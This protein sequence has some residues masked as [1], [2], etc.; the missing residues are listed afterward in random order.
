MEGDNAED[1]WA[2]S[3]LDNED[4]KDEDDADQSSM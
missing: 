3:L 2:F 1:D 4:D